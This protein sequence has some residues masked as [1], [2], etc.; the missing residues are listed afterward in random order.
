MSLEESI[1][2][3]LS[4]LNDGRVYPDT[5]PDKPV[6]PAT[7]YQQVGGNALWFSEQVVPDH[8][9][10]RLQITTHSRTRLEANALARQYE[11]A[12][13]TGFP[14][15]RPYG[16]LVSTYNDTLKIYTARQDFGIWYPDNT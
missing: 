9:H 1:F 16:A 5:L 4:P 14:T 3:L 6:F 15:A 2:N 13:C 12:I 8:K 7:S 11:R 10:A